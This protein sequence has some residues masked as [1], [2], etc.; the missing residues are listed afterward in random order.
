MARRVLV[1]HGGADA[2]ESA[3]YN[4]APHRGRTPPPRKIQSAGERRGV[5]REKPTAPRKM[6]PA[7]PLSEDEQREFGAHS[8]PKRRSEPPAPQDREPEDRAERGAASVSG[9]LAGDARSR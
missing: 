7:S 5:Q 4:P 9:K 6:P 2:P 8:T 1:V 3:E